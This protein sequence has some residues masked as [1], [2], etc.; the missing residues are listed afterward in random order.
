VRMSINVSV[1]ESPVSIRRGKMLITD[2]DNLK[3]IEINRRRRLRLEQVS[4]FK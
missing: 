3:K 2:I 1:T 4:I